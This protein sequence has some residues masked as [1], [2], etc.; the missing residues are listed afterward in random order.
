MM[1][2]LSGSSSF[3]FGLCPF[4]PADSH[5]SKAANGLNEWNDE[6]N[7]AVVAEMDV[8]SVWSRTHICGCVWVWESALILL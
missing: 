7:I 6:P 5:C 8:V 3:L 1:P 4:E 2:H